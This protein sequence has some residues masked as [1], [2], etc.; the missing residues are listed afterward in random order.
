M[1][2]YPWLTDDQIRQ[3]HAYLRARAR[4]ALGLRAPYDPAKAS[5][6]PAAKV[7]GPMTY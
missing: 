3:L 7:K 4:E 6:A 1:P 2:Q 5:A